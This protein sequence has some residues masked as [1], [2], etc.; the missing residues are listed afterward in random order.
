MTKKKR[1]GDMIKDIGKF[2]EFSKQ[3][4]EQGKLKSKDVQRRVP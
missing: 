2:L 3:L 4:E 1:E